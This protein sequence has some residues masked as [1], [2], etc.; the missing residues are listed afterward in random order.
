MDRLPSACTIR[1]TTALAAFM[2]LLLSA[3]GT[4][5]AILASEGFDYGATGGNLAGNRWRHRRGRTP[6]PV[7][8]SRS[9]T[10]NCLMAGIG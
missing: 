5:A 8:R 1:L 6:W 10:G 3:S 4:H 2:C 7:G 9:A